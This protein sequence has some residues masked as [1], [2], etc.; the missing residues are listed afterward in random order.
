MSASPTQGGAIGQSPWEGPSEVMGLN[1]GKT[2]GQD[3]VIIWDTPPSPTV[4]RSNIQ[5]P[6]LG[7]P[8]D[9]MLP[10]TRPFSHS[11]KPVEFLVKE[12]KSGKLGPGL[13]IELARPEIFAEDRSL[14][15][16]L[17][18]DRDLLG[19]NAYTLLHPQ[20]RLIRSRSERIR[21]L[22]QSEFGS[23]GGIRVLSQGCAT[24]TAYHPGS[25][26]RKDPRYS[27]RGSSIEHCDWMI[28]NI[29]LPN[30]W[31]NYGKSSQ[32]IATLTGWGTSAPI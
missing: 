10:S 12:C 2:M 30:E 27:A 17:H 1:P 13:E 24:G 7:R 25:T 29:S 26:F 6:V 5:P 3:S 20:D 21:K 11:N 4:Q 15:Q 28:T 8:R 31:L 18:S 19:C 9:G 16:P 14:N 22:C 23:R 32:V